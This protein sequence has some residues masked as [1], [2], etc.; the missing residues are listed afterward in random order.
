MSDQTFAVNCGF[1]DSV[2]GDRLYS[3]NEMNRPYKRLVSNGVFATQSG[4][5]STDLQVMSAN[6]GMNIICKAGEG[7]FADKWFENPADIT[8]SV[9]SN[10]ELV[11]RKDSV[12][13][14]VDKTTAGRVGNIVY[15]TGTANSN[16][17][18]PAINT[19]PNIIEYRISNIYVAPSATSIGNDVITDLRGSSE[20]LWI[21]SLVKQVDTS[22]LFNQW[23]SAYSNFYD[24]STSE[25]NNYVED[26]E[27]DYV[28]YTSTKRREFETFLQQLTEELS[29]S[30]NVIS[31]TSSFV[32]ENTASNIPINIPSFDPTTDVLMV[33]INGLRAVEGLNYT[34]NNNN[35]SIDLTAE[36]LPGQTVN[37]LVFKSVIADDINTTVTAIQALNDRLSAFMADSGWIEFTLQNGATYYDSS[38]IPSYKK[39]GDRVYLRGAFKGITST[40]LTICT[41]PD[42]YRPNMAHIYT[43]CALNSSTIN[44][45]VALK[46]N[47]DGTIVLHAKSG[48]LSSSDLIS[49]ATDF[50]DSTLIRDAYIAAT[51]SSDG[52]MS[53]ADKIK[54]DGI[55]ASAEV[56]VQSDW[57]QSDTTADDYITNKPSIPTSLEDLTGTLPISQGGTG[58]TT[59]ADALT[60]LGAY[61]SSS[62]V[63]GLITGNGEATK[64][65]TLSFTPRLIIVYLVNQPP[66]KYDSTNEYYIYNFAIGNNYYGC[67]KGM[68]VSG[69]NITLKQTQGTPTDGIFFNLNKNYGQYVYI[70]F[71]VT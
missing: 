63:A 67:T 31:L 19:D 39:I 18:V 56:N 51:E 49:L 29:V 4:T 59:V 1:F 43:T 37:F 40:G 11:P 28:S 5:P 20:C 23:Q 2:S 33:F 55:S 52:L 70:A 57:S 54:L 24:T 32:S 21:T 60:A 27:E 69:N 66:I 6:N 7:I 50:T 26:V 38:S 8:I 22:T 3:A 46:I 12:I 64:T 47:T 17:Q 30:T 9:P 14:Q 36:L 35:M 16:P 45:T 42:G 10:T 25:F 58:A 15:R 48:A 62:F 65:T 34:I 61:P 44:D 53:A 71:K 68:T 13:V 41:L